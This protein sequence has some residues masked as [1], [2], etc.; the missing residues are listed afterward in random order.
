[1]Y[2]DMVTVPHKM[3][4]LERMTVTSVRLGKFILTGE[5]FS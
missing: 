3:V 1:M 5:A 4:K 2:F